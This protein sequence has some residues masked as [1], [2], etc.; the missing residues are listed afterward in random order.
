MLTSKT[1]AGWTI[2]TLE[3]F[4]RSFQKGTE[5]GMHTWYQDFNTLITE[6][7]MGDLQEVQLFT[8]LVATCSPN[9]GIVQNAFSALLNYRALSQGCRP[10]W[11]S[12]PYRSLVNYLAGCLGCAS[13]QKVTIDGG[14]SRRFYS[15]S[16]ISKGF[17]DMLFP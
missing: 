16:M 3:D 4:K 12:Y 15:N 17:I 13:G 10:R 14:R 2:P 6:Y 1:R 7:C 9:S 8:S 11:G 5:K